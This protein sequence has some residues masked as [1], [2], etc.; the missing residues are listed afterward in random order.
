[1]NKCK[2]SSFNCLCQRYRK[3]KCI[4][5]DYRINIAQK[6]NRNI[7]KPSNF[8]RKMYGKRYNYF[9]WN[10]FPFGMIEDIRG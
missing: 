9:I 3:C 1:M 8:S 2:P 5:S 6:L 10:K 7:S 4:N